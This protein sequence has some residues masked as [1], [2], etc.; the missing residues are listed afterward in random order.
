VRPADGRRQSWE[1]QVSS[2]VPGQPVRLSWP[3]MS[4]LP[5][6]VRPVLVDAAAGRRLYMRTT[7]GY[8]VPAD[9]TGVSRRL[10]IEIE[11][12]SAQTLMV[13]SMSSRQA[14]AGAA[15]IGFALSA[16]ASVEARVLNIAGRPVRRIASGQKPAG[17]TT[18]SWNLRDDGGRLVPSGVYLVEL[19]A[20]DETGRQARAMC[21]LHVIR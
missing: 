3:D 17:T 7:A 12:A 2:G 8:E 18:L 14:S 16:P 19:H 1:L 13:T 4:G 6:E 5:A 20:R 21:S 15:Q 9:E 10:R 11:L